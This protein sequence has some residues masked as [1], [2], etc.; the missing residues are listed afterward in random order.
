MSD[1]DDLRDRLRDGQVVVIAGA[2]VSI[3]SV[4]DP[5]EGRENVASWLGLLRDGVAKAQGADVDDEWRDLRRTQINTGKVGELVTAAE[6]ITDEMGGRDHGNYAAW[7]ADTVGAL[8]PAKPDL[9]RALHGLG[10]PIATTNYDDLIEQVTS[11]RYV[12]WRQGM[13]WQSVLR[14]KLRGK[15]VLHIHGHYMDPES[16]ILGM[17]SYDEILADEAAQEML[18]ALALTST[19]LLVGVGAGLDDPNFGALRAW[20][21]R[22]ARQSMFP[23]YRLVHEGELS[24]EEADRDRDDRIHPLVYGPD[25][26]RLEPW[27]R[28]LVPRRTA[29]GQSSGQRVLELAISR[30]KVMAKASPRG[31]T[32]EEPLGLDRHRVSMIQ[33]LEEWLRRRDDPD[34]GGETTSEQDEAQLLGRILYDSIIHGQIKTLYEEERAAVK[35]ADRLALVLKLEREGIASLDADP[36]VTL[37]ALPWELLHGE[38]EGL[39]ARLGTLKL[40]RALPGSPQLASRVHEPLRILVAR[41]QPADVLT[42]ARAR[43]PKAK[44]TAYD[45]ALDKIMAQFDDLRKDDR[46]VDVQVLDRPTLGE[47][48]AALNDDTPPNI[49]HY[50]GYDSLNTASRKRCVALHAEG[51]DQAMWPESKVFANQFSAAPPKLVFLHLCEGP[52][53][54]YP[55]GAFDFGRASFTDLARLLLDGGVQLVVAMQYPM[56]PD[57]GAE[58]TQNFYDSVRS[59]QTVGQAVQAARRRAAW[60]YRVGAP[61]LYMQGS[62][63]SLVEGNGSPDQ[64]DA[65]RAGLPSVSNRGEDVSSGADRPA[66]V[67]AEPAKRPVVAIRPLARP[68]PTRLTVSIADVKLEAAVPAVEAGLQGVAQDTFV[69][70]AARLWLELNP[71]PGGG[72]ERSR[73]AAGA[74]ERA[75][76]NPGGQLALLWSRLADQLEPPDTESSV[77]Y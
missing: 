18:K 64:P 24:P 59:G 23:H 41:A 49:V 29:A 21:G 48:D 12:T 57:I 20:L 1:L 75:R 51:S 37:T 47:I 42:A 30:E 44:E 19:F 56:N 6:L 43:W 7:L 22:N 3:A 65:A 66:D 11:M 10:T 60:F 74:R 8:T 35:G 68:T 9:I 55:E 77:G 15:S 32:A 72:V 34:S 58:F 73:L 36:A 17:R 50:I 71:D 14:G 25:H 54:G 2:G 16:V 38:H 28:A 45:N 31:V 53:D 76:V 52:R 61:I 5:P 70:E 63:E 26:S 46:V 40:F 62:D 33:M 69:D 27:L 67:A 4:D 13:Q 39:L